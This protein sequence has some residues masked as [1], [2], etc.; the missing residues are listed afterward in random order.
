MTKDEIEERCRLLEEEISANE[1]E[2]WCMQSEL[3][4]LYQQLDDWEEDDLLYEN[5]DKG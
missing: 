1:K 3:D 4:N 2:N 5:I